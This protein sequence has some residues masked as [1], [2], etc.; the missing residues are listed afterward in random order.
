MGVK[1]ADL[2]PC[3]LVWVVVNIWKGNIL[4]FQRS[5]PGEQ[6]CVYLSL[7]QCGTR[8]FLLSEVLLWADEKRGSVGMKHNLVISVVRTSHQSLLRLNCGSLRWTC[9]WFGL[10]QC[11]NENMFDIRWNQCEWMKS[12]TSEETKHDF[13]PD[14]VHWKTNTILANH[15]VQEFQSLHGHSCI[16][17]GMQ[18]LLHTSVEERLPTDETLRMKHGTSLKFTCTQRQTQYSAFLLYIS[19]PLFQ[20]SADS[21][22]FQVFVENNDSGRKQLNARKVPIRRLKPSLTQAGLFVLHSVN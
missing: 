15:W 8:S 13:L 11:K 19:V 12:K 6:V 21:F 10:N 22:T 20:I 7:I 17:S 18:T 16:T 1:S 5:S 3:W 2:K 4:I 9:R 14:L